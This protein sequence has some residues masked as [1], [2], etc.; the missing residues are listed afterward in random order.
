MCLA[1]AFVLLGCGRA[2]APSTPA[3]KDISADAQR[4]T[5]IEGLA[6]PWSIAFFS[7]R[8]ALVTEKDGGLKRIDLLD[9]T[10]RLVKGLPRDLVDDIRQADRR[11]NAGLFEV[12]VDP[13]YAQEPWIYLS[14]AAMG[15]EGTTTKVIRGKL[16]N[17]SLTSTQVLLVA[18]PYSQDRFHYGGGMVFGRDS[19]LYITIGERYYNEIDQ[20]AMPVAQD[21]TDRRGMIYRINPSGSIPL[22]NPAMGDSAV[23]GAYAIGIRA[24]QGMT[25]H[26]E[27]GEIWF[28]EHGSQQGDEINLLRAGAN[29]GWPVV[30]D[31]SYRNAE[32]VPPRLNRQYTAPVWSWKGTVAPTGLVFYTGDEF[33]AWR[34]N[35]FVA[36][37]STGSLWRL[38]VDGSKVSSAQKLFDDEP[39]RLRKVAQS[40][41]GKLYVLTDE[42]G[43]R[44]LQIV[45]VTTG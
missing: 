40:P 16:V 24:A 17:D 30:T 4:V 5:I 42:P 36:G 31:G 21:V 22:D 32:F 12:L 1:P 20:P 38:T 6:H 3:K 45:P 28:S 9:K 26:P 18:E 43:G 44:I 33:P 11:D 2:S 14:Y 25:L 19:K 15:E 10:Q 27:T 13:N 35:L 34:G 8:D 29:Y 41:G 7:E 39:V 23:E 37:L